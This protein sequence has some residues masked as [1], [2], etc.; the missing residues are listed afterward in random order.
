[1]EKLKTGIEG[2]DLIS[3]G[4]LPKGRTSL[5]C[6]T[7]GSAKT[8]FSIQF[9]AMGIMKYNQNGVFVTF[10]EN[11]ADIRQNVKSLGW[12][13][14]QWE[15]EGKWVFVDISPQLDDNYIIS[16]EYDLGPLL[17]RIEHAIRKINADR[18]SIDS[19]GSLFNRFPNQN[20]IRSGLFHLSSALKEMKVT[21]LMTAERSEEYGPVSRNN[22][23]EFVVDNVI[24]LRNILDKERRRRTLEILKFRG[25]IHQNGEYPFTIDPKKGMVLLPLSAIKLTQKS[26]N[27]R[28]SSG[29]KKLD[30]MCGGGFFKD[31]IVLISGATGCGKTL[32]CTEFLAGGARDGERCLL[33]AFE[34]SRDQ[35]IRNA[36]GWGYDY[37]K[38]E[39][40]GLIKIISAYPE[41]T[42]LENHL[43]MIKESI[44]EFKPN[45]VA[46]DSLS[47]LERVCSL[48][49]FREFVITLT[50]H[51]K[52]QEV[53]GLFTATTSSLMGGT[54]IT[55]QHI[56]TI[57][58]SII[59]LRYV[60]VFGEMRRGM[61]VLKMR[62]SLHDR[63]I[64]EYLIDGKGLHIG[65]PFRNV[66]GI[67]TGVQSQF[68]PSEIERID[69][70]FKD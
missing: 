29:N 26:S 70:L 18:I 64:R 46:I 9:L 4:G 52:Q 23:E 8:V 50:S 10:E 66:S 37:E 67:L 42:V 21:G 58:D 7:A 2:F 54:S 19:L 24:L 45:R 57:T 51:L 16:G 27:I 32:M 12:D 13:V 39:R 43:L 34:E 6:G 48:K 69:A 40:E 61:T 68:A 53:S 41:S 30:E 5:V 44:S 35:L 3:F 60:E 55:E 1:M 65:E 63:N 25:A 15:N 36:T 11:P 22:V 62:G 28:K 33:F 31:S 49:S 14:E 56:S 20:V 38:W 59:L 17:A 47:A